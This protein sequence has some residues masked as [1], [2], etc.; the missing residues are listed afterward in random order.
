MVALPVQEVNAGEV[1]RAREIADRLIAK[2]PQGMDFLDLVQA[3]KVLALADYQG[4][5]IEAEV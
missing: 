2:G 3:F 1:D 5:P 4:K